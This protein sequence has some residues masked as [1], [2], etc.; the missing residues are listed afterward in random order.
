MGV[1]FAAYDPNIER[2]VAVKRAL[3]DALQD[4]GSG[5]RL[6]KMFF[7]EAIPPGCSAIQIVTESVEDG[8][9][10]K[11]H[12]TAEALLSV[13][14]AAEIVLKCAQVVDYAH[15]Q[16]V[17]HRVVKPANILMTKEMDVNIEDFSTAHSTRSDM[18]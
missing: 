16:G 8:T 9:R 4:R 1:V 17:I 11:E 10:L 14:Q 15:K 13:T 2:S 12:C 7:N 6:R 18:T 5:E 3:A